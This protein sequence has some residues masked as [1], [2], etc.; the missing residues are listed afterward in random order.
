M[1]EPVCDGCTKSGKDC[2]F[3]NKFRQAAVMLDGK[4]R[5]DVVAEIFGGDVPDCGRECNCIACRLN[6]QV[7]A[8][9]A[10]MEDSH[11]CDCSNCP[12]AEKGCPIKKLGEAT[13]GDGFGGVGMKIPIPGLGTLMMLPIP[14]DVAVAMG[15][16]GVLD[17]EPAAETVPEAP[18]S[19]DPLGTGD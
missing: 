2:E 14:R 10:E 3:E 1:Y 11:D 18:P 17:Q 5:E 19:E 8:M 6:K 15:M 9:L 13:S 16:L 12:I 4:P 7:V